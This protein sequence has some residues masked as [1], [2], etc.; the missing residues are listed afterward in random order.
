MA[1]SVWE[2]H[3][4]G[5]FEIFAVSMVGYFSPFFVIKD[6]EALKSS[7]LYAC[8]KTFA[9]GIILSVAF[10]HLLAESAEIMM[11]TGHQEAIADYP[12]AFVMCILGFLV[13][14]GLEQVALHSMIAISGKNGYSK[15]LTNPNPVDTEKGVQE[16]EIQSTEVIGHSHE[17][18]HSWHMM[19]G[20]DPQSVFLKAVVLD[21][22]IC[23]HSI[24]V[25]FAIGITD[26]IPTLEV[27]LVA[28]A[29][30]QLFEGIGLGTA[31]LEGK[32]SQ[33]SLL[34]MGTFFALTTPIGIILGMYA[35][36]GTDGEVVAGYFDAFAAGSLIYSVCI[37]M[38]GEDFMDPRFSKNHLGKLSM[39]ASL[40]LGAFTMALIAL[41][42]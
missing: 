16:L 2:L 21:I 9:A 8:V 12:I 19:T 20:K 32:V 15:S 29:F 41:W 31:I 3:I 42:G 35:N 26:D 1:Y 14:L 23:S 38:I 40:C 34:V 18:M 24:I 22:S 17:H 28:L 11:G 36:T 6:V 5:I 10:L 39:Y 7:T 30:H 25:G 13:T 33:T 27:L 37:E 4:I